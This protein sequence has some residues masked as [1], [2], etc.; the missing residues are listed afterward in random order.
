MQKGEL[1]KRAAQTYTKPTLGYNLAFLI[2][3]RSAG[4]TLA[5]MTDPNEFTRMPSNDPTERI[6]LGARTTETK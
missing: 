5:R 4:R 3:A 6:Y 1:G 2:R